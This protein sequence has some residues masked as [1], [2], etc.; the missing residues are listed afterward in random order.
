MHGESQ[1]SELL[2]YYNLL[3]KGNFLLTV[4]KKLGLKNCV[5]LFELRGISINLYSI[6]I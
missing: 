2:D 1:L 5:L 4:S 6:N 3:I